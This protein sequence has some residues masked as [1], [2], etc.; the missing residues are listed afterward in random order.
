MITRKEN[1]TVEQLRDRLIQGSKDT[2]KN[3]SNLASLTD[4]APEIAETKI[5]RRGRPRKIEMVAKTV[6]EPVIKKEEQPAHLISSGPGQLQLEKG[7][8]PRWGLAKKYLALIP[9]DLLRPGSNHSVLLSHDFFK[10]T[11]IHNCRNQIYR[12]GT[13]KGYRMSTQVEVEGIRIWRAK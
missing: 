9:W 5:E 12:S 8:I 3:M 13:N 6:L 7:H 4:W 10:G 11:T 1:E 2:K